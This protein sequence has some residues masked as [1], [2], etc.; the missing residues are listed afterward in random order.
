MKQKIGFILV[1][2]MCFGL[3]TG[4]GGE[5]YVG[6]WTS[7]TIRRQGEEDRDFGDKYGYQKVITLNADGSFKYEWVAVDGDEETQKD[8]EE[9]NKNYQDNHP[10][11]KWKIVTCKDHGLEGVEVWNEDESEPD[12]DEHPDYYME[13]GYLYANS[14]DEVCYER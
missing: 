5:C 9:K 8:C 10:N 1:V 2:V 11:Q 6:K 12:G 13:D 3:F 7:T 4:C 14:D